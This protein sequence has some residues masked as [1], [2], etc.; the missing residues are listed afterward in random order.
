MEMFLKGT[1]P[2]IEHTI[3]SLLSV[4]PCKYPFSVFCIVKLDI[5][6]KKCTYYYVFTFDN[7]IQH[8]TSDVENFY[9]LIKFQCIQGLEFHVKGFYT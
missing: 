3:D 7:Y 2:E 1:P 9:M 5:G 8:K 4:F 6:T